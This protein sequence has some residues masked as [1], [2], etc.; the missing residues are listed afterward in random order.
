MKWKNDVDSKLQLPDGSPVPCV[1]LANKCDLQKEGLVCDGVKMDEFCKDKGFIG[2]FETSAKENIGVD[3]AAQF[4][5][6]KILAND[7]WSNLEPD[8]PDRIA[9]EP[10][11]SGN[12]PPNKC[13][14]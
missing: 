1:L 3:E 7:I 12:K 10:S 6:S 14:C 11:A 8:S 2:W 13:N 5:V 4:L 9:L